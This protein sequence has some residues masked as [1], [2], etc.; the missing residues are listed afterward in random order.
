MLIFMT[1]MIYDLWFMNLEDVRNTQVQ[2]ISI[3]IR[4]IDG[5]LKLVC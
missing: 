5:V 4:H 3:Q 1:N 2:A